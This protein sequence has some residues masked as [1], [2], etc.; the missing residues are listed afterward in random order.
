M[1][2]TADAMRHLESG[3]VRGKVAI[4]I[5]RIPESPSERAD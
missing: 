3:A 1:A 4:I 5:G 2:E